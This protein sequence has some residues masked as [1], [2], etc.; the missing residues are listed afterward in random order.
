MTFLIMM[1]SL[2]LC[3]LFI[4]LFMSLESCLHS[5]IFAGKD[6][7]ATFAVIMLATGRMKHL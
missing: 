2:I 4:A 7:G 6:S 5:F 1:F 3:R